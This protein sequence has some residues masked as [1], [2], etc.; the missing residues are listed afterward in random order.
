ERR[1]TVAPE[2]AAMLMIVDIDDFKHVNDTTGHLVG[3]RLLVE[4]ADRLKSAMGSKALVARLGGDEF[5]VYR[6]GS[7]SPE[8]ADADSTAILEAFKAPFAIMGESLS[9]NVSIGIAITHDID[10]DLDSMMTKSDLALYKA[11]G[12]GKAQ[13]QIFHDEMD[14]AYRYRQRLKAELKTAVENDALTLVYQPL[15]DLETRRVVACEAL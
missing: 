2:E 4:A 15:V 11:K 7:V 8:D 6:S 12:A 10:D 9:T 1:R 3:D 13:A 5:I 14:T